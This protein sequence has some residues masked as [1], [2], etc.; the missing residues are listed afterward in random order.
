VG[1]DS[2]VNIAIF[3][4]MRSPVSVA[5]L[6]APIQTG[7]GT[8]PASYIIGTGLF[9][10]VKRSGRG[11]NHP[12]PSST[13]VK[14]G[15]ELYLCSPSVPSWHRVNFTLP[16]YL[17]ENCVLSTKMNQL[18]VFEEVI[19][20]IVRAVQKP[21]KCTLYVQSRVFCVITGGTVL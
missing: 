17:A 19:F 2:V 21:Y 15:I 9:P 14:E 8:H 1:W 11:V 20:V 13:K 3:Y 16:F 6:S 5:R 4:V 18:M 7:P 12:S 10:C